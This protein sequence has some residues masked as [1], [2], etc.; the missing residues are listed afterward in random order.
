VKGHAEELAA[1][2]SLVEKGE[3]SGV[4]ESALATTATMLA[5]VESLRTGAQAA[6]AR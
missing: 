3:P 1:F 4:T 5:A 2:R 6:P